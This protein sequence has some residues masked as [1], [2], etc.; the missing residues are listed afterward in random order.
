MYLITIT[1][2]FKI[3]NKEW[4][5]IEYDTNI[6]CFLTLFERF[7]KEYPTTDLYYV[8][9]RDELSEDQ[10]QKWIHEW[11]FDVYEYYELWETYHYL[12]SEVFSSEEQE[13]IHENDYYN[14]FIEYMH[15]VDESTLEE[16]LLKKTSQYQCRYYTGI[17]IYEDSSNLNSELRK[18]WIKIRDNEK[19]I[20]NLREWNYYWWELQILFKP[21]YEDLM[22]A[23]YQND[24]KQ[25]IEFTDPCVWLCNTSLGS[26][27]YSDFI[28]TIKLPFD[29]KNIF[30]G[31]QWPWY[32]LIEVYW[33]S[34]LW[35][36]WWAIKQS[37]RKVKAET[38]PE[39]EKYSNWDSDLKKGICHS[40]DPRWNSHKYEY[41]NDYPCWWKCTRCWNFVID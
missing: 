26:W 36:S 15:E 5:E 11:Y 38:N 23:V 10:L 9:Y 19:A 22:E 39:V 28:W 18:L 33:D 20:S 13:W 37:K 16:D 31:T 35:N 8:D 30:V 4:N 3:I 1:N 32:S 29:P 25:Y 6:E 40:D 21:D 12:L 24:W 2:M 34:D 14:D 41:R 17:D 27:W 7:K